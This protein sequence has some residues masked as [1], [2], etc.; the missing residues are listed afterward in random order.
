[1][2]DKGTPRLFILS[3]RLKASALVFTSILIIWE[4]LI[5]SNNFLTSLKGYDSSF[6]EKKE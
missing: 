1:M 6:V 5:L 3:N 4:E 2:A